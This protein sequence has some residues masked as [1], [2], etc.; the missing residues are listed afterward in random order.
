MLSFPLPLFINLPFHP[1]FLLLPPLRQTF[2]GCTQCTGSECDRRE[3]VGVDLEVGVIRNALSRTR[4]GH[5]RS[6]RCIYVYAHTYLASPLRHSLEPYESTNRASNDSQTSIQEQL[7]HL[8]SCVP[9]KAPRACAMGQSDGS[10]EP[11]RPRG[12]ENM[13]QPWTVR[14]GRHAIVSH[15]L[16]QEHYVRMISVQKLARTRPRRATQS[17]TD[18]RDDFRGNRK[19]SEGVAAAMTLR[20]EILLSAA[21]RR[22]AC[23]GT[24]TERCRGR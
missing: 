24:R 15:S 23:R 19:A 20:P 13:P 11:P 9:R 1:P 8:V 18:H 2:V 14:S 10:T 16:T 17:N 3:S 5:T 21:N 12:H 22:E 6:D 7:L 4:L